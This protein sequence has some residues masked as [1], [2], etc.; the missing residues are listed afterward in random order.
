M[1]TRSLATVRFSTTGSSAVRVISC[2]A[3]VISGPSIALSRLA[4]VI[5]SRVTLAVSCWTLTVSETLSVS[6]NL[7]RWA[8]PAVRLDLDVELL[9]GA[10]HGVVGARVAGGRFA[11]LTRAR[12][13][14]AHAVVAAEPVLVFGRELL[15]G[16]GVGGVL[17]L[18]LLIGHMDLLAVRAG[19]GKGHEAEMRAENAGLDRG[20]LGPV[21]LGVEVDLVQRAHLGAIGIDHF[22]AAPLELLLLRRHCATVLV[23]C[24]VIHPLVDEGH[25]QRSGAAIRSGDMFL[26]I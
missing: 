2:S 10:R 5:G 4:S 1:P 15:L 7:R 22:H 16:I 13:G 6:T 21:G 23:A 18:G 14:V 8:R 3:V 20:P 12:L 11:S 17:D 24:G 9:L 19:P 25:Y 26:T